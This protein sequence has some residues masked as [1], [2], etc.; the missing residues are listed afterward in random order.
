MVEDSR[1]KP[2]DD[3]PSASASAA[4]AFAVY[5]NPRDETEEGESSK[6]AKETELV[7]HKEDDEVREVAD[8][9]DDVMRD[10]L[11]PQVV[12]G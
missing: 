3:S 1:P 7:V 8:D 11:V 12:E 5:R 2:G 9:D 4:S 6:L 10:L